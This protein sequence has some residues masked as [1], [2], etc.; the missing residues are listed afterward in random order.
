M[1]SRVFF[2]VVNA[3]RQLWY[4]LLDVLPDISN[5]LLAVVGVLMSFPKKA[6]A[7]EDNPIL[8]R[9][10]ATICILF[11]LAGLLVS[12][13]Q[14]RQ[15]NSQMVTLL[16]NVQRSLDNTNTLL[17]QAKDL[18]GK[19][20]DLLVSNQNL[21]SEITGGKSYIYLE[22]GD[23]MGPLQMDVPHYA[24][25]QNVM[26]SRGIP[27]FIG[28]N[29]L[30]DVHV[31]IFGPFGFGQDVDYGT[32][33][34]NQVG[35][36]FITPYLEFRPD[37]ARQHVHIDINTSNGTYYQGVLFLKTDNKW[38][39]ASRFYKGSGPNQ[40]LIRKWSTKDFPKNGESEWDKED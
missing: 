11:G 29:P 28:L 22:I 14:R 34:P 3:G 6:Q 10:T 27:T 16:G 12:A 5:I 23:I 36:P 25:K 13:G 2:I 26:I 9:T 4:L 32:M 40:K 20:N 30:H 38:S 35:K 19:T 24:G 15:F 21:W 7:I 33:Y 39:W 31:S 18:L 8:R 1:N 37:K 17:G